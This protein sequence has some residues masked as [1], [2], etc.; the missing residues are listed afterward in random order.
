MEGQNIPGRGNFRVEGEN[1]AARTVVVDNQIVYA[2][3]LR[4]GQYDRPE[5]F[6]IFLGRG[7][8]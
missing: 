7:L 6:H 8:A 3:N 5:L 2:S 1:P 4:V